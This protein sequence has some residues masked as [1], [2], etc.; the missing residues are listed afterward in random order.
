VLLIPIILKMNK[1]RHQPRGTM[2]SRC[3]SPLMGWMG[4][5]RALQGAGIA[6]PIVFEPKMGE[7]GGTRGL[8]WW[9]A[10]GRPTVE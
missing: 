5:C 3:G 2:P 7:E 4:S 10:E 1:E 8:R 6:V 9:W